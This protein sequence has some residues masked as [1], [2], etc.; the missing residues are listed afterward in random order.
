MLNHSFLSHFEAELIALREGS[1]QFASE[2]PLAAKALG[3]DQRS[4]GSIDRLLEG[5]AFLAARVGVKL[6]R[7]VELLARDLLASAI[8]FLVAPVPSLGVVVMRSDPTRQALTQALHLPSGTALRV[9]SPD[10]SRQARFKTA[11]SL[12]LLPVNLIG[13]DFVGAASASAIVAQLPRPLRQTLRGQAGL[14]QAGALR[15]RFALHEQV[16]PKD[17]ALMPLQVFVDGPIG[18]VQR[19]LQAMLG[20]FEALA[21]VGDNTVRDF[22]SARQGIESCGFNEDEALFPSVGRNYS[23]FRWIAEFMALPQRFQFIRMRAWTGEHH[24]LTEAREFEIWL[25]GRSEIGTLARDLASV[26]LLLN[27]TPV[28]N[29]YERKLDR[30]PFSPGRTDVP[31]IVDRLRPARHEIL[32]VLTV[33][34]LNAQGRE[35]ECHALHSP[36]SEV[37]NDQSVMFSVTREFPRLWTTEAGNSKYDQIPSSR[38]SLA[39]ADRRG[40]SQIFEVAELAVSALISDGELPERL[41]AEGGM[42]VVLELST[43]IRVDFISGPTP[44]QRSHLLT[45]S[46]WQLV[47]TLRRSLESLLA[48]GDGAER[49]KQLLSTLALSETAANRRLVDSVRSFTGIERV[50]PIGGIGPLCFARGLDLCVTVANEDL[51]AAP[52]FTL[53]VVLDRSLAAHAS[54]N[55]FTRL[56]VK[57]SLRDQVW[58]FAPRRGAWALL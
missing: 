40:G 27:A 29:A 7:S 35:R 30:V 55:A 3:L 33:R 52:L 19:V 50:R 58:A 14:G 22:V 53:S 32:E 36:S 10:G 42:Q 38:V 5:V 6:D 24:L 8:P 20:S 56:S 16:N 28:I 31:L 48:E 47:R 41:R 45:R 51:E 34:A 11:Q 43:D 21:I 39:L 2:H 49:L 54:I 15:M 46:S 9:S 37:G 44:V 13:V 23:A 4:D 17:F 57:T 25:L 26:Q 12:D 18:P 1:K